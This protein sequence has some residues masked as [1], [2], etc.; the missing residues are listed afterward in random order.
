MDENTSLLDAPLSGNL[1]PSA[2]RIQP[3]PVKPKK[4]VAELE[5]IVSQSE[6]VELK[7]P[8]FDP[9]MIKVVSEEKTEKAVATIPERRGDYTFPPI[10]L[11]AEAP[12]YRRS[13]TARSRGYYGSIG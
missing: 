10:N 9:S 11:L 6:P 4:P 2:G 12:K 7:K 3:P 13:L 8:K 1:E 5:Q